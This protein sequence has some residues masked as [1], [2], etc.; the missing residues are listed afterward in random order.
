VDLAE[1]LDATAK[2]HLDDRTTLIEGD[3]DNLWNDAYLVRQLNEA[4]RRLCRAAWCIIEN[5]GSSPAGFIVLK[6]GVSL[7]P[8]HKSVLR[9]FDA[10]PADQTA[11]LGRGEDIQLRD[12]SLIGGRNDAFDAWEIGEQASL[13]GS[14][15]TT[16]GAPLAVASDAGTR[17]IRIYPPPTSTYNGTKVNLKVARYPVVWL[18]LD[19]TAAVPEVPEEYHESLVLYAAGR[20]LTLPN[21]DGQAKADGRALLAEFADLLREA[22]HDR[23][24]AEASS[25]RWAFST[26]TSL[27]GTRPA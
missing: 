1:L 10:T 21:V 12:T 4:Q 25:H 19:D 15:T 9:V 17:V 18:T 2:D 23:Q 14:T 26:V 27:L 13:A 24:R 7:Y 5:D 20:A 16:S 6:T 11:P 8:V 22:R 3:A